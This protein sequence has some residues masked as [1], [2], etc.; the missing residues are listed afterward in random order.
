M[1]LWSH[2]CQNLLFSTGFA[3]LAARGGFG[4]Q[5]VQLCVLVQVLLVVEGFAAC[6]TRQHLVV[7]VHVQMLVQ[8]YRAWNRHH[9]A[10][11]NKNGQQD[12]QV[13][14]VRRGVQQ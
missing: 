11:S 13:S 3:V 5:V 12:H 8:L 14:L 2:T 1:Y 6:E 10:F 9:A 4:V 7:R